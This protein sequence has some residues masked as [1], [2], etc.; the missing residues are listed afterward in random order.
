MKIYSLLHLFVVIEKKETVQEEW[1][2][3]FM[4]GR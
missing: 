2:N 1:V 3:F 4:I